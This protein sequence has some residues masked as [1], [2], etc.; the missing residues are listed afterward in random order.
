M[1]Q[2]KKKIL[3]EEESYCGEA[4]VLVFVVNKGGYSVEDGLATAQ[5]HVLRCLVLKQVD[6]G[7][8]R[9]H[10]HLF[11]SV[12]VVQKSQNNSHFFRAQVRATE[13]IVRLWV[14]QEQ[15]VEV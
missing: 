7:P 6:H 14:A 10:M 5:N 4:C 15:T 9:Q 11:G 1:I 3:L 8:Q 13:F 2:V 12:F